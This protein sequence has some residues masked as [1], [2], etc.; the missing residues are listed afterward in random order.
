LLAKCAH[1]GDVAHS[2]TIG[3]NEQNMAAFDE[4]QRA[5]SI[6]LLEMAIELLMQA[7]DEAYGRGHK[8]YLVPI[9]A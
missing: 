7:V 4:P 2:D 3:K 6:G 5:M 8:R 1:A 9:D